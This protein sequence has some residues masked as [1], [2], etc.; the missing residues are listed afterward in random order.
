MPESADF[1]GCSRDCRTSGVH[2]L[3]WGRCEYAAEAEPAVTLMRTRLMDDGMPAIVGDRLTVTELADLIEPAL[4]QVRVHFGP[5]ALAM[6]HRGEAVGLSG[7]EYADL[8]RAAAEAVAQPHLIPAA[9]GE[10][11]HA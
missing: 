3:T 4:R 6:L 1:D 7:G 5:N 9:A 11:P 2:T 8:A 10:Q